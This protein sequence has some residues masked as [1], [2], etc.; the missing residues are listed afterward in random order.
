MSCGIESSSSKKSDKL[1]FADE[2]SAN[3]LADY[4]CIH[5]SPR[6]KLLTKSVGFVTAPP[7]RSLT[8]T[9]KADSQSR[10]VGRVSTVFM[11]EEL[12]FRFS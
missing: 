5:C 8:T 6:D 10:C 4:S 2:V 9:R 7:F 12:L 11:L 1:V 3:S